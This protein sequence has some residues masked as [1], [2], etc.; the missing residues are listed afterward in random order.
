MSVLR[1]GCTI[2]FVLFPAYEM[3]KP[4]QHFSCHTFVIAA[5]SSY[6]AVEKPILIPLNTLQTPTWILNND[7]KPKSDLSSKS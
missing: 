3:L 6:L 7:V 4:M 1:F 2:L 5:Q